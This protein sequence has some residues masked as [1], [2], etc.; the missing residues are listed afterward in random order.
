MIVTNCTGERSFSKLKRIKND[1]RSTIRQTRLNS[2]SLLCIENELLK[3]VN[4]STLIDD[5]CQ[6]KC[7]KRVFNKNIKT[8][9]FSLYLVIDTTYLIEL[10]KNIFLSFLRSGK[11]APALQARIRQFQINILSLVVWLHRTHQMSP[12]P[13]RQTRL[14][15]QQSSTST[16]PSD[17]V[18]SR[19]ALSN[20]ARSI[21][22]VLPGTPVSPALVNQSVIS[23]KVKGCPIEGNWW[24]QFKKFCTY[25]RTKTTH[26]GELYGTYKFIWC[27]S[28]LHE[29]RY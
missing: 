11:R 8:F 13:K 20:S 24:C 12:Q 4:F 6:Q 29:V 23:A 14:Q 22:K 17:S 19:L 3:S 1:L 18:T 21:G 28:E 2:L 26:R 27:E 16:P 7:R 5:F 25:Q 15:L 9:F 10:C